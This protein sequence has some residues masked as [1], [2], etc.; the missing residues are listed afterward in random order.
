MIFMG[1]VKDSQNSQ[2][3]KFVM[4]LQYL[5]KEV[6]DEVDFLHAGK[7]Q[8]FYKLTLS[9][10]MEVARHVKVP[11]IRSWEFFCKKEKISQLLLSSIVIE[12]IQI[13]YGGSVMFYVTCFWVFVV[14]NGCNLLD[15]GT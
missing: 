12:N 9:L 6:R 14:K 2:K 8:S 13:I 1:M 5:K 3:S 10:L 15:H 7:H 4:S 11:K